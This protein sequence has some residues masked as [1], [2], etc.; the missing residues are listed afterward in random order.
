MTFADVTTLAK[1]L[2]RDEES[3]MLLG[4]CSGLA[5]R[6]EFSVAAARILALLALLFFTLPAGFVYLTAG[7]LL[8]RKS[9]QFHGGGAEKQFW[10]TTG[11]N[12]NALG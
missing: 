3:A 7:A 12:R 8:P 11:G 4:V 9:L 1:S 10:R 5:E 2:Y 6:F